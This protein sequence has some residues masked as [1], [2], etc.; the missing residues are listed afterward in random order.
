[1]GSEFAEK[2]LTLI[3]AQKL[4]ERLQ[5]LGATVHLTRDDDSTLSLQER[6]NISYK[7]KPDLFVSLHINSVAETTN[8][9]NVRGFTVWYRNP[10]T[11]D[12]SQTMLDVMH[13]INPAT[14]RHK[15]I[16]Q[17][18]FFVCR[19]AWT[20]SVLLEAGFIINIDDF[21]WLIDPKQQDRMADA[22]ATAILEYFS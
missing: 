9:T 5:E 1:M 22:T 10:N 18:N 2:H 7:H 14:N 12:I 21:A 16:N 17:S 8:A 15:S 13:M 11:I 19:P 3:N 4:A 20:P 6:V